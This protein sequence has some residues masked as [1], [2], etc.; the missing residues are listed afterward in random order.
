M[1]W[2][3]SRVGSNGESTDNGNGERRII[4]LDVR[5]SEMGGC[6]SMETWAWS[7]LAELTDTETS[8]VAGRMVGRKERD[9][10]QIGVNSIPSTD[11]WMIGP[12][13]DSEYA[14]EPV[15]VDKSSLK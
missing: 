4:T 14:V 2:I 8:E 13:A 15:G 9:R 7:R 11:G 6:P 10:G 1:L 3:H 5:G 12:P